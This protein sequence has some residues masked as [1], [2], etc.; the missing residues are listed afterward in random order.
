MTGIP[1]GFTGHFPEGSAYDVETRQ[2]LEQDAK[3]IIAKY[4]KTRSAL[5]P[6]LHLV[7]S[8]DGCVTQVG[9]E[10]CASMLDITPA[11][12]TGVATFYTQYKR[13]PMGDYHV[14]VC[15][16]TLCAVLGGDEIWDA[17][18]EHVGVGHD[19][20]TDD[21]KV[22]LERLECNAACDFAPVMMV[23]WE[24]YDNQTPDSAK[25]LVDDLR[26]GRQVPPT[27]GPNGLCTFKEA[28]R[29][30]A[31]I[32]DGRAGEGVQAGPESLV[33]LE[34]AKEKGWEAP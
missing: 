2:R 31:G 19:E 12:V 26:A 11:Q 6:L 18:S 3:E 25:Q 28:S 20:V 21:G 4:P 34:I 32:N 23:N 9:V 16:N 8:V 15:I 1:V 14:G 13:R 10:F 33:G 30:L 27:R 24:F 5:L 17:L 29:V 22:S 7:Q